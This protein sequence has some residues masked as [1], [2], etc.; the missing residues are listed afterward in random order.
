MSNNAYLINCEKKTACAA[1]VYSS[2]VKYKVIATGVNKVP[3][4]WFFCFQEQDL[5]DVKSELESSSAEQEIFSF[6]APVIEVEK[7]IE[8]LKNSKELMIAFCQD[9]VL[10]TQYW[11]RAVADFKSLTYPYI[12]LDPLEV[13]YLNVPEEEAKEFIKCYSRDENAFKSIKR[14][15][16]YNENIL[17]YDV[18]QFYGNS[19]LDDFARTCNSA[20]MD[21]GL[22]SE[23]E[24]TSSGVEQEPEQL[25]AE[26]KAENKKSWW[27]FW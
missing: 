4:P 1:E 23:L 16:F 6:K 18:A 20:S 17:P 24:D 2:N 14:L 3:V 10:G 12:F 8:N 22:E 19:Q 26:E 27:K 5:V 7:A 13:L 25:K 9:D 15:T 21:M 11:E